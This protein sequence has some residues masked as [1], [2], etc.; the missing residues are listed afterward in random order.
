MRPLLLLL[1]V[2]GHALA[3]APTLAQ[4]T[5]LGLQPPA[6]D[7]APWWMR[8]PVI[9]ST[10]Q[11]KAEVRANRASF[12]AAFEVVDRE[13]ADATRQAGERV[14]A[15]SAAL[16]A[17][18]PEAVRVET[19]FSTR[20]LYAQYKDKDG[21]LQTNERADKIDRY[22][23]SADVRIEVR[24][25]SRLERVYAAVIAARPTSVQQVYFRLEPD[26][27]LNDAMFAEAVKDAARRARSAAADAGA[28]L[29]AVRLIDPT[30]RACQTD[31][32]V[33]GAPR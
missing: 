1:A 27:A 7:P 33:T 17:Y 22:A 29:G 9:A 30:G 13:V 4:A 19:T 32:L 28:R 31:V 25:L 6:Y 5:V 11:V 8:E 10:G 3:P 20:P 23:V 26:N 14:R 21:N 18:G 16:A 24:D 2:A 15:L 12:S